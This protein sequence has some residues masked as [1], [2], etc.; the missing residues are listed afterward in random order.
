MQNDDEKFENFLR[1]FQPRAP[2]HLQIE[3]QAARREFALGLMAATA[4]AVIVLAVFIIVGRRSRTS[5]PDHVQNISTIK[6]SPEAQ[7]LT[8]GKANDLLL[9][10]PSISAA[11]DSLAGESQGMHI[12]KG[13]HSAL[14]ILAQENFKER[15]KL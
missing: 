8:L 7:P 10:A 5:A 4:A 15:I 6:S 12:Q 11:I 9:H 13:M 2:R 3:E 14:A 1:Q